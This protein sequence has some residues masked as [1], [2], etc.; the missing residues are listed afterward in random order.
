MG[1]SSLCRA[2]R[3]GPRHQLSRVGARGKASSQ[4]GAP[5]LAGL[6]QALGKGDERKGKEGSCQVSEE[7]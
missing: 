4:R 3:E 7:R 6:V 2:R 5:C 1:G